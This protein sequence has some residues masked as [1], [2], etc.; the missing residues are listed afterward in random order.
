MSNAFAFSLC[1]D[2]YAMTP[3]ISHG[4]LEALDAGALS[5]TSVMTTFRWWPEAAG[6]LKSHDG[7]ID[8]GLHLNL[9]LGPPLGPM[10]GLAPDG[11]LPDIGALIR[12]NRR[13]DLPLDEIATEIDRQCDQFI[14]HFGRPPDHVDGHQHVHA[15]RTIR[16][17]LLAALDRRG[18]RP[19]LRDSADRLWRIARRGNLKKALALAVVA[20]G[21]ERQAACAGFACNDGFAG[22]SPFDPSRS[23]AKLFE[24]Y[25][26]TP[27]PR[28]L[29]MCHPG[30]VDEHLRQLDPVLE[31]REQELRFLVSE[32]PTM[33]ARR[34]ASLVRLAKNDATSE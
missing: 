33:L 12:R 8:I 3:G 28:H 29:V 6:P 15:L 7:K 19:W 13:G 25:L 9:T 1:A 14:A 31:T 17:I 21:F 10:P 2:D 11:R 30:Y 26:T 16:P 32:L 23:Y 27:G 20:E 22:F 34:S 24:S 18:W 4:I 5:A